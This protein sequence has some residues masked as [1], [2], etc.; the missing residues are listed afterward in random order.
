MVNDGIFGELIEYSNEH[1]AHTRLTRLLTEDPL[2]PG[3][4]V[5]ITV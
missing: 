4:G 1:V 5:I 2:S 3:N